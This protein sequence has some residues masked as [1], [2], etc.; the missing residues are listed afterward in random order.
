M[1]AAPKTRP[2]QGEE[3]VDTPTS[4]AAAKGFYRQTLIACSLEAI[5]FARPGEER[6]VFRVTTRN[7]PQQVGHAD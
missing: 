3:G 7:K 5:R 2:N 1:R 4:R 6:R